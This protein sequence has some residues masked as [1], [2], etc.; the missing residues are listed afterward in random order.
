MIKKLIGVSMIL[1]GFISFYG[2]IPL[3]M[4]FINPSSAVV[5]VGGIFKLFF[6][7]LILVAGV[8]VT[9]SKTIR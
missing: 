6:Y 4:S 5:N 3:L 7:A 2:D 9:S 1:F 8:I